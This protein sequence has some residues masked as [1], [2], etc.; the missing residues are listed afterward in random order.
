MGTGRAEEVDGA[1]AFCDG[2]SSYTSMQSERGMFLSGVGSF[3]SLVVVAGGGAGGVLSQ[4]SP[5]SLV[6]KAKYQL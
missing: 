6:K 4:G 3:P 5:T 2:D 1:T